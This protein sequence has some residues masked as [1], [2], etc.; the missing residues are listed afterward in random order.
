MFRDKFIRTE[1]MKKI[2]NLDK[3]NHYAPLVMRLALSFVFLWFGISQLINQEYFMGYLPG[4]LPNTANPTLFIILNGAAETILGALLA[5][6]LFTRIVAAILALHLLGIIISLGYND[7]AIRDAGLM[8][9]TVAQC[10]GGA[11]RWCLDYRRKNR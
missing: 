4:F 3:Y 7:I 9:V 6:G 10:I 8:L 11:D 1:K 5:I 2:M